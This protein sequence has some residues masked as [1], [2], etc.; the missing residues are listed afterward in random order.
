MPKSRSDQLT[1]ET[2]AGYFARANMTARRIYCMNSST[3][4]IVIVRNPVTRLISDYVHDRVSHRMSPEAKHTFEELVFN[5]LGEVNKSYIKVRFSLYDEHMRV[6]LK[7]F[8]RSNIH[9]INGESFQ[10]NPLPHLKEVETF[11]K[12]RQF[13]T[14]SQFYLGKKN[15]SCLTAKNRTWPSGKQ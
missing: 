3:K 14:K 15:F 6:W 5:K 11:L 13:F 7:Y 8:P 1:L 9:V 2:S 10:R 4:L 12:I